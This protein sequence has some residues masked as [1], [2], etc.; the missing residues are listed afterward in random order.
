MWK[1]TRPKPLLQ[2]RPIDKKKRQRQ[3][4]GAEM[5]VAIVD[6]LCIVCAAL[7]ET[8][9]TID[10]YTLQRVYASREWQ[11]I[12]D[13]CEDAPKTEEVFTWNY[14]QIRASHKRIDLMPM[15]KQTL[16][17]NINRALGDLTHAYNTNIY[18]EQNDAK[19]L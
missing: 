17:K 2:D 19:N 15:T 6:D 4:D 12:A 10:D 7:A 13:L 1:L 5:L 9:C 16:I 18:E 3:R 8:D 14:K 11:G